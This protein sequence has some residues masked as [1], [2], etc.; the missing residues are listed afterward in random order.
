[1][2][3][4]QV[5]PK[6]GHAASGGPTRQGQRCCAQQLCHGNV[7]AASGQGQL[8]RLAAAMACSCTHLEDFSKL[9]QGV[10]ALLPLV[11][12][13]ARLLQAGGAAWAAG[14]HAPGFSPA[15]AGASQQPCLAAGV[16]WRGRRAVQPTG[17]APARATLRCG[18]H[19]DGAVSSPAAPRP[20]PPPASSRCPARSPAHKK[21]VPKPCFVGEGSHP[22]Q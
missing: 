13:Q 10:R 6:Q 19:V 4:V 17:A 14:E 2:P 21:G 3:C 7:C 11:S 5:G 20:P 16:P 8:E 22:A 15:A 1:M 9:L 12:R 18:A